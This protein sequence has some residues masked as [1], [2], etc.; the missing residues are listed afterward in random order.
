MKIDFSLAFE[1]YFEW[2]SANL[3]QMRSG[4]GFIV[5]LAGFLSITLGY[6]I[7]RSAPERNDFFPGGL[8]LVGGLL[9]T[10][11]AIPVWLLTA[12]RKPAKTIPDLFSEFQRFYAGPRILEADEAGWVFTCGTATNK[13]QWTD[14]LYVR[15]LSKTFFLSDAFATYI[16]PKSAFS[17]E[18]LQEFKGFCERSL[19]PR[20]KLWSVLMVSSKADYVKALI[21]H[22]WSKVRRT[23]VG[24]YILGLVC[25][26][27]VGLIVADRSFILG[28]TAFMV[29]VALLYWAQHLYYGREFDDRY[30]MHSFQQ[31]HILKD[32]VSFHAAAGLSVIT[33]FEIRKIPYSWISDVCETKCSF[34]VYVSPKVLYL[35]PKAGFAPDQLIQFRDLL[36]TRNRA[37][38]PIC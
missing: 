12:R 3:T 23:A 13:R 19:V 17:S 29:L 10:F 1:D 4:A 27:F 6:T 15:E 7:L 35:L 33:E 14:L 18:Q 28:V 9:T 24:L 20:E 2:Q 26:L 16:L 38:P 25:V 32:G 8:F 37:Q 36:Q 31:A 11:A 22:N 5:A 34:M 30:I 21:A